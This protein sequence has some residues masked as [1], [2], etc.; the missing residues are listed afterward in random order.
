[1]GNIEHVTTV[2]RVYIFVVVKK[3]LIRWDR[4]KYDYGIYIMLL[5]KL[6]I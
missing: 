1:M 3:K 5:S 6:M 4:K 2:T